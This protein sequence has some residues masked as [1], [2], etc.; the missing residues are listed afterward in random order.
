VAFY[1]ADGTF[2]VKE[3]MLDNKKETVVDYAGGWK[4]S[5]VLLNQADHDF[6]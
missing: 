4:Y 1:N 2:D 6:V 5:A 3:V